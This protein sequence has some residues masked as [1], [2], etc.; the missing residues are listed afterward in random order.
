MKEKTRNISD[1]TETIETEED[2]KTV[3]EDEEEI[4]LDFRNPKQQTS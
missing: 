2:A 1:Y 3:E 4:N